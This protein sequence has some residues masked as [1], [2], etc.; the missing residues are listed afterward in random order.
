MDTLRTYMANP[1]VR[2]VNKNCILCHGEMWIMD[3]DAYDW[4]MR[5]AYGLEQKQEFKPLKL[6]IPCPV[7]NE[8]SK[9]VVSMGECNGQGQDVCFP[10]LQRLKKQGRLP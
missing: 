6:M 1:H 3:P 4:G 9:C 8:G 2:L 5:Q 7:C 10:L